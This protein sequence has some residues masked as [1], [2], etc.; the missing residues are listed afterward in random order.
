MM[1]P[2]KIMIVQLVKKVH[3]YIYRSL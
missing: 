2:N 1:V 3:Y